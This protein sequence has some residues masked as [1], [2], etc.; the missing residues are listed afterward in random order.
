MQAQASE[1]RSKKRMKSVNDLPV[2]KNFRQVIETRNV[3]HIKNELYA[4][5]HLYCSFI[6][7]YNISGFRATYRRHQDFANAF[8][9]HFEK[10]HPYF[11]GIYA[12]HEEP[13]NDTGFTKADIK[14]AFYRIVEQHKDAI[15]EWSQREKRNERYALYL[16]LKKEFGGE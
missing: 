8:I 7:L 13:Y 4:F 14:R 16:E 3:E 9:C 5:L 12:C 6:A 10:D 11:S 1:R 15:I 2:V